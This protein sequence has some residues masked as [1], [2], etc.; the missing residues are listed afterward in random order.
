VRPPILRHPRLSR[1][2]LAHARRPQLHIVSSYAP[3]SPCLF[4]PVPAAC[5]SAPAPEPSPGSS[6]APLSARAGENEIG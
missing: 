5:C 3:D 2:T 4:Q 1:I 6:P